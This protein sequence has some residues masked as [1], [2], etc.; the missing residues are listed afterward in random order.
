MQLSFE[1]SVFKYLEDVDIGVFDRLF[2][3][4]W[5]RFRKYGI[6]VKI[7]ENKEVIIAADGW[8][9]KFDLFDQCLFFQ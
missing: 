6:T 3:A 2:S 1:S 5:Y 7:K 9:K 4:V 8:Y